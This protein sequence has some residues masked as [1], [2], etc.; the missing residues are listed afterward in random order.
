[1][2]ALI[3]TVWVHNDEKGEPGASSF[4]PEDEVPEWAARQMGAHCFEGGVHPYGDAESADDG[5][6][7]RKAGKGSSLE[8]WQ[9]YAKANDFEVG[10]ASRDEIIAALEADGIPTE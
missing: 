9:K 3:S 5:A 6:I 8:A 2:S 1:M 10:D 7:P 4:G